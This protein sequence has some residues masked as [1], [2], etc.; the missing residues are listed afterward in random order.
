MSLKRKLEVLKLEISLF[1]EKKTITNFWQ[2]LS[3][4]YSSGKWRPVSYF[5]DI[6]TQIIK[7]TGTTATSLAGCI[8]SLK[9]Q[10]RSREGNR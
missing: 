9:Q 4:S 5:T 8:C 7:Y 10:P 3:A 6:T 2:D 1:K